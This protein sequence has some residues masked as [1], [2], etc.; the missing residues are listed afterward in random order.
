MITLSKGALEL[1]LSLWYIYALI[2]AN[3]IAANV[4]G[5]CPSDGLLMYDVYDLMSADRMMPAFD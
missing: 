4:V 2:L 5:Q 3:D 1:I